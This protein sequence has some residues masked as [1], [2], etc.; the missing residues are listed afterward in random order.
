MTTTEKTK[1]IREELKK[2]GWSNRQVS[3]K[4][5]SCGYSS[6]IR[7]TIKDLS[8]N[9]EKVEEICNQF[10]KID[11]DEMSGEILCGAN[12]YVDVKWDWELI[13]NEQ[14][15]K[16]PQAKEIYSKGKIENLNQIIM[17]EGLYELVYYPRD[18]EARLLKRP[19]NYKELEGGYCLDTI[20]RYTTH[21]EFAI[22]DV[23]V[24]S[25]IYLRNHKE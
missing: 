16:L 21:N 2:L 22:A 23:I 3:V 17:E 8:V 12:T 4:A 5:D 10:V 25:E 24:Y 11:R 20:E 7:C 14:Q 13:K 6:S 15:K 9:K 18:N 1:I 19:E